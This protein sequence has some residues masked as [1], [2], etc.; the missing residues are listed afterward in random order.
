MAS[1][2]KGD[3]C[4][5]HRDTGEVLVQLKV[6]EVSSGASRVHHL[7]GLTRAWRH[8]ETAIS[9]EN[10]TRLTCWTAGPGKRTLP[11]GQV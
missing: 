2:E 3:A 5:A 4:I 11:A 9:T 7:E 10:L 8:A 6:L 1:V